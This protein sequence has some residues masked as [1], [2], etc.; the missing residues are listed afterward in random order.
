M[1]DFDTSITAKKTKLL[2]KSIYV[3]NNFSCHPYAPCGIR[4]EFKK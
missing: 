4:L 2:F 1:V 3:V